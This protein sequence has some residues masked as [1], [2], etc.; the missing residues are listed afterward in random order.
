MNHTSK[1]LIQA[2]IVLSVVLFLLPL[3]SAHASASISIVG[4]RRLTADLKFPGQGAY[5]YH[6]GSM[7]VGQGGKVS[8]TNN[9]YDQHTV[10][11]YSTKMSVDFEGAQVNVPI[12]D[13]KFDSLST[14]GPIEAGDTYTLDTTGLATGDYQFF[15]QIHPWMQGTLHVTSSGSRT[16]VNVNIDHHQG[17]TTQFFS[18]SASWGFQPNNLRVSQGTIVPV[19]NSGPIFHTFSSYTTLISAPE[20]YK[21]LHI[22]I[23]DGVINATIAPGQTWNLDT[24]T[25]AKGTYTYACLFHPW[26]LGTLVV[27]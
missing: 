19:T 26:M 11:S 13:G 10:T 18:G 8:F 3:Q 20:G 22:P 15:C 9:G 1:H 7:S 24:G 17:S 6:P 21:T 4:P 27:N 23:S 5:Q 16:T 2:T 12:P 25:L 14:F